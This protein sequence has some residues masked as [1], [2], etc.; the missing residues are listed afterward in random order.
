M[1]MQSRF[2]SI[3]LSFTT[4]LVTNVSAID[5]TNPD[6]KAVSN[7]AIFLIVFGIVLVIFGIV[8]I[9]LECKSPKSGKKIDQAEKKD[10]PASPSM[11]YK[12]VTLK[13]EF[14]NKESDRLNENYDNDNPKNDYHNV[15]L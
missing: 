3:L 1:A 13:D 9:V 15:W 10:D 6:L 12:D 8:M 2:L 14:D 11:M 4:I 5:C 7:V